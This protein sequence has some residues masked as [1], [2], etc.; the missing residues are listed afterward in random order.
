MSTRRAKQLIY[1]TLY[2]LIVLFICSGIYFV[3]V[4]PIIAASTPV[5]CTPGACAPTSTAPIAATIVST[6]VTSPGHDTFLA[7]L[8]NADGDFGAPAVGY[9]LDFEDASNTV[10]Q[11]VSGQT[12]IYPSQNK[13]ILLPNEAVPAS[14]DHVALTI[15]GAQWVSSGTIGTDPGVA[16]GGFALQNLQANV[17]STT[18]SVGGQLVNTSVASYAQVIVVALFKDAGGNVVGASQTELDNVMAGATNDFSVLYPA[19]PNINPALNQI[20]VYAIR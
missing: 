3:I 13:Y 4:M 8:Q 20:L 12:F 6:F 11:S 18:V 2:L 16:P 17:A 19:A 10:I 9:E 1:G 14:Y 7:Q 15:T 5:P